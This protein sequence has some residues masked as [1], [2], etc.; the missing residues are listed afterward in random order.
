MNNKDISSAAFVIAIVL[1][2]LVVTGCAPSEATVPPT[3]SSVPALP[4]QT[5]IPASPTATSTSIPTQL[6]VDTPTATSEPCYR[7]DQVT[8]EMTGQTVCVYGVITDFIQTYGAATRYRFSSKPNTFF[9][10]GKNFEVFDPKTGKTIAP[11]TCVMVTA[12]LR[13]NGAPYIDL[14][15]LEGASSGPTTHEMNNFTFFDDAA[16]CSGP[17]PE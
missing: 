11:G 16:A 1:I 4:T 12:T 8:K 2:A 6:P 14:G 10:F 17:P 9:L 3:P 7:W 15:D 5:L 13:F